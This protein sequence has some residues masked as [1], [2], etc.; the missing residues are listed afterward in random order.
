[1]TCLFAFSKHRLGPSVRSRW[2]SPIR[3]AAGLISGDKPLPRSGPGARW[4][5]PTVTGGTALREP[6]HQGK[7]GQ[8][9]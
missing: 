6:T 2:G 8:A 9:L 4:H 5:P 3:A 1:M 7:G